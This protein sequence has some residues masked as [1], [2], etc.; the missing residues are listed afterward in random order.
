MYV[1]SE[2]IGFVVNENAQFVVAS[3]YAFE[4]AGRTLS[5]Y[6]EYVSYF[7]MKEKPHT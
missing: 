6:I 3:N 4:R 7:K 2:R 5:V 1:N